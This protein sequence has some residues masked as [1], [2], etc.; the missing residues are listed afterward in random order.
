M[1]FLQLCQRLRSEAGIAGTGPSTVVNQSGEMGRIVAWV[2]D[3]YRDICDKRRDWNFLR[4][5]FTFNLVIGTS[6]YAQSTVSNLANWKTDSFRLYLT[7][8][9][10]EQ[11]I[12]FLPWEEFRD[13]RLYGPT[14]TATG[15]PIEFSVK[16]DKTVTFWPIPDDTYTVRGEFFRTAPELSLDADEPLFDRHHMAIVYNALMRNAAHTAD[17]GTYSYAEK[18]YGRL[19]NKLENERASKPTIAGS[20]A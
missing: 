16:P 5:D 17:P 12:R 20:L 4:N 13:F 7:T 8:V 18:E 19:I 1:N 10:D 15:R 14:S 11:W 3:A 6:E 9:N 2:Q